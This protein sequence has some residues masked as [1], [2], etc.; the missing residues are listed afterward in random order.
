MKRFLIIFIFSMWAELAMAGIIVT[1]CDGSH[2]AKINTKGALLVKSDKGIEKS[3]KMDHN[4]SGGLFSL[5][6]SLLIVYGL[7]DKID[8]T[9][10]Q[11]MRLSVY[12]IGRHQRAIMN[13]TYGGAIYKVAFSADQR[14]VLVENQFGIDV[15]NVAKKTAKSFDPAYVAEF[16]MQLC[17]AKSE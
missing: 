13:E 5:D 11:V 2:K 15:L 16:S 6:N 3:I 10:P 17:E 4:I 9:Y 12:R 7:P 14:F 1:S 8:P